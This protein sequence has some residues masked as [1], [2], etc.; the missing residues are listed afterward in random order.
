MDI[1]S[2]VYYVVCGI[3]TIALAVK[4]FFDNKKAKNRNMY[5]KSVEDDNARLEILGKISE[6]CV[7]AEQVVGKGNGPI[8]ELYVTCRVD[9]LAHEKG[10][11]IT[12][13]EIK[14]EIEK[15]LTAPQKKV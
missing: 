3:I 4:G 14:S 15:V 10:I 6:F 8:K 2:I 1:G 9:K 11:I 5:T 12:Q 7:E 13:D